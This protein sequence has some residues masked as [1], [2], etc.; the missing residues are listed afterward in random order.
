[1]VRAKMVCCILAGE[2][3]H[4]FEIGSGGSSIR[5]RQSSNGIHSMYFKDKW[6]IEG[7]GMIL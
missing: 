3:E 5:T 7:L 6:D 4:L 1:M 2:R